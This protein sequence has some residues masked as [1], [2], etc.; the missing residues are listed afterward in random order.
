[1]G[2]LFTCAL[3]LQTAKVSGQYTWSNAIRS[4]Y[5]FS[6][7]LNGSYDFV[8]PNLFIGNADSMKTEPVK[9]KS[10]ITTN[11]ISSDSGMDNKRLAS[12]QTEDYNGSGYPTALM[13]KD[14]MGKV[15]SSSAYTYNA[16]GNLIEEIN[17]DTIHRIT[18]D[19]KYT[20]NEKNMLSFYMAKSYTY[21]ILG[22][23]LTKVRD[24]IEITERAMTITYN[25][26]N[27]IA[28]IDASVSYGVSWATTVTS[29][30]Y[31]Y[32]G[33]KNLV[34]VYIA[35]KFTGDQH[36]DYTYGDKHNLLSTMRYDSN[37]LI[38]STITVIDKDKGTRTVTDETFKYKTNEGSCIPDHHRTIS[39]YDKDYNTLSE[40]TVSLENEDTTNTVVT[41]TYKTVPGQSL[42]VTELTEET[43]DMYYSRKMDITTSYYDADSNVIKVVHKGGGEY[44]G[45]STTLYTFNKYRKML[46][47]DDYGSCMDAPTSTTKITYY[48]NDLTIKEYRTIESYEAYI[49]KYDEH[50]NLTE[51]TELRKENSNQTTYTYIY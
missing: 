34:Q 44:G 31:K 40:N 15:M 13:M 4:G 41:Y 51:S 29:Y 14:S 36:E 27:K 21:E 20:Y 5:A 7:F 1:M 6:A 33:A 39:V 30:M 35:E 47:Q 25:A 12:V 28:Q 18:D 16:R 2:L 43:G 42:T 10:Q 11:Y 49:D 26:I 50:G 3:F 32:D 17:Y 9:F 46:E 45:N 48:S 19:I 8:D 24:T 38:H 23:C 37:G 22:N